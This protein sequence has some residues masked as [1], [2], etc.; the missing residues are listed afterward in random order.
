MPSRTGVE[1]VFADLAGEG[2]ALCHA[3]PDHAGD[4][5]AQG[6]ARDPSDTSS[7]TAEHLQLALETS[8][9]AAVAMAARLRLPDIEG[10]RPAEAPSDPR[11]TSRG[12]RWSSA[13]QPMPA[14][15]EAAGCAG[16][17]RT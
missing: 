7:E 1:H 2:H 4:P 11:P 14:P 10:E 15:T 16:S 9:I 17:A 12:W 3:R 13:R 8:D 5:A 6:Q